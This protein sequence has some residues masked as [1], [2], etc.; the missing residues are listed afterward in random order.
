MSVLMIIDLK[1]KPESV[2]ELRA[3]LNAA[4]TRAFAGNEEVR[5][6]YRPCPTRNEAR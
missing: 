2:D 1:A 6:A 3:H 4:E 5:H